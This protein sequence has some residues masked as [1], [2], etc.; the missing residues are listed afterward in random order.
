MPSSVL[1]QA[2]P[3]GS[4]IQWGI[5]TITVANLVVVLAMVLVFVLALV[6]PFPSAGGREES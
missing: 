5:L 3:A 6:L 2:V 1:A 4:V